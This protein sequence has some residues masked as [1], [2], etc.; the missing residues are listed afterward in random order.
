MSKLRHYKRVSFWRWISEGLQ[1]WF[2]RIPEWWADD[3]NRLTLG[4]TFLIFFTFAPVAALFLYPLALIIIV[5][6][7]ALSWLYWLYRL[8]DPTIEIDEANET[9]TEKSQ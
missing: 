4:F 9:K 8:I 3:E 2:S 1:S 5:P 7:I 6:I